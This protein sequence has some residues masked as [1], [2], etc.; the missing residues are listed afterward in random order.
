MS[1]GAGCAAPEGQVV[2]GYRFALDPTDAQEQLLRS[3]CGAQ[4][5]AFNWGLGLIK[6]NLDQRAAERSYGVADD[7]LT[8]VVGWSAYGLRKRWNLVKHDVAP[9]WRENSKEAYS[10]GLAN[11]A[12]ALSNWSASRCGDR[13]G[14]RVRFPRFKSKR[15][16]M[17][18]RF[19]TGAF[20]LADSDR[21]HVRLPRIGVVRTHE[22][23]RKLARRTD[24]GRARIRSATVTFSR[25][26]WFVSFSVEVQRTDPA[27]ARPNSV[28]GVDLGVKHLAVL[29][30]PVPDVSDEHGMVANP[31]HLDN[32]QRKLRRL[33]RQAA[34]RRGPDKRSGAEPSDAGWP[35]TPR[36]GGCT[37]GSPTRAATGCTNSAPPSPIDSAPSSS[38]TCTSPA[39][40][41]TTAS[42]GASPMPAGANCADNST[43]R[44]AGAAPLSSSPTAGIRARKP[45]PTAA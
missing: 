23:T 41:Q 13:N 32:A 45:A 14:P 26:R 39:C 11:L 20:G 34:R 33:Q 22:S 4:R 24:T 15:A 43:T 8:A 28:I 1:I 38:R 21:R 6:M 25:G 29:S 37:R 17:S 19:S 5:R 31:K 7:E 44:P 42:R 3:H 18:C 9:W 2:Q 36:S 12:A 10:S 16:P 35:P 30:T 40:W 27:P